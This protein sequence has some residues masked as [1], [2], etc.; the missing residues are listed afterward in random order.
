M[1]RSTG[2]AFDLV[3]MNIQIPGMDGS[4]AARRI[5]QRCPGL[6]IIGLTAHVVAEDHTRCLEAGMIDH[7]GKPIDVEQLVQSLRRWSKQADRAGERGGEGAE[8]PA[9]A[10]PGTTSAIDWGTLSAR[11]Y[12][13]LALI[14]QLIAA[15]RDSQPARLR[16]LAATGDVDGLYRLAQAV[17]CVAANLCVDALRD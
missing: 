6:A 8:Q 10:M 17:K 7:L 15:S 2:V 4:E 3:L 12:H 13:N 1:S 14:E 9:L 16:Q 5:R 11:F